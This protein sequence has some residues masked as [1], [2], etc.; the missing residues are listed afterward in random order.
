MIEHAYWIVLLPL[1]SA[2]VIFFL[3]RWLPLR[4]ASL[5]ILASGYALVH[6]LGIF[7]KMLGAHGAPREFS[8]PWFRFGLFQT[9]LGFLIDGLAAVMLVVVT[10]VSFLVQVYSLGYMR[11]DERFKRY[12]AYLSFFT[13]AM[14]LLVAA[15]NF[16]QIFLGWELVGAASYLLIGFW[17]EKKEAAA[18]GRKAF[19]TT[20]LGDLGFFI[21]ILLVFSLLGTLN[22][23][24]VQA[25]LADGLVSPR[26]AAA[27][28]LLLFLGAAGK[29]AQAPLHIWLPDAMEGPTPVSALIH[30]ATMVAAGVYLVARTTF[31]FEYGA[32]SLEVV[33]WVGGIT[34][35][36]AACMALVANDIKRVLA[37]STISQLGYMM[38][39]MGVGGRTAG[40][41]HLTNHAFFK[42]LLFLCAGSVIHAVHTN[43]IRE[44]GGLSR[45]MIWTFWTFSFGWIAIC[46]L[47]PFAGFFSKDAI[48]EAAFH[49]G[50]LSLFYLGTFTAF[51]TAFYMTRLYLLVFVTEPRNIPV[52]SR[53]KE[54]PGSMVVPLVVL[55]L[56]SF[57]SGILLQYGLDMEALLGGAPESMVR[58]AHQASTHAVPG[59]FIPAVSMAAVLSGIV[60]AFLFYLRKL[61]SAESLAETFAPAYR[62]LLKRFAFDEMYLACLVR[63]GDALARSLARFDYEIF[64]RF[65]IDGTGW[66]TLR[67]S[68]VQG[69]FDRVVVDGLVDFW[70]ALIQ[71]FG[72]HLRRMQTGLVQNYIFILAAGFGLLLYWKLKIGFY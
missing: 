57:G 52:F 54:S 7:F 48:L 41:F 63:P 23:A 24:Q 30:A 59:W 22:F 49:S 66:L 72:R 61:F 38:L 10:L 62:L 11:G 20:K 65:G 67:L 43:D 40:I 17:F 14:L 4:G 26:A 2:V 71:F 44:M 51:L 64:D 35:L 60:L 12:Y 33:A 1:V 25:R 32:A 58:S 21:A 46:G 9:E 55:A 36:L 16:L 50:H 13:F 70:G 69:W 5:G 47:W 29:S 68:S 15:N 34:A 42:A 31:L 45:K 39:A 3:G 19:I 27:I 56:L 18:A 28:A 8:V 53:V 37:F 6:S